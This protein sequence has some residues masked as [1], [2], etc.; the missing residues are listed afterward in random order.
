MA[1][2]YQTLLY[3]N[4]SKRLGQG[5]LTI[6]WHI[7]VD[8]D[9]SCKHCYMYES[10]TYESEK[11]NPLTFEEC[12][13]F[14]DQYV[15][16]LQRFNLTGA[17]YLTGGDPILRPDFWDLLKYIQSKEIITVDMMGNP[18]HITEEVAKR[19]KEHG[20][21][22]YQISLDG[23]E[24]TH[25]Y[26]RKKGSFKESL[27]ALKVLNIHGIN[28]NVMFTL[29]KQNASELIALYQFLNKLDYINSFSFD[30][31]VPIGLGNKL[32]EEGI[33]TN[34]EHRD[35]L[36]QMFQSEIDNP[37]PV[38]QGRKDVLWG[39]LLYEV[40]LMTPFPAEGTEF[41]QGCVVPFGALTVLSDGTIYSCR[42]MPIKIGKVPED[43]VW[44]VFIN[45]SLINDF[46]DLDNY[47]KCRECELGFY[48]RG[49]PAI[50]YGYTGDPF[51][52]DPHC[53]KKVNTRDKE[54][55]RLND[56]P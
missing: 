46:R 54:G 44:D 12:C 6:Q 15:E 50:K 8:C 27:H 1:N 42:R 17:Y 35:I 52:P 18:Y 39:L 13:Q 45:N 56:I 32:K 28:N 29:S 19:L 43:N 26:L 5:R 48:C 41:C 47:K 55:D 36:Y 16:I 11:N 23:L 10:E 38:S 37:G 53:W 3:G 33:L 34:K 22:T 24:D 49:C 21:R 20:V 25:D 4:S 31:M 14:V 51:N 2:V 9:Q 7:T 30:R 40:G